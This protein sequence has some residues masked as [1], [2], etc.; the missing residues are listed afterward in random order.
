LPVYQWATLA[1]LAVA[2]TATG[3]LISALARSE[4]VAAA[5]LPIAVIP[6]SSSP[7]SSLP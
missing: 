4:K 1:A 3:L 7:G 5:L 2:R 6:R